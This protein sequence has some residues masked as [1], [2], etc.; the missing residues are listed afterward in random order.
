M[1]LGLT[2]ERIFLRFF[3]KDDGED[4]YEYL[5]LEE[6]VKYEPYSVM[7]KDECQQEAKRRS[8]NP[9]FYAIVLK[10]ENKVI[11]NIYFAQKQPYNFNTY[12]LGYILNPK[13]SNMG[14]ATEA[15][16]IIMRFGFL[17]ISIHRIIANCDQKN[18]RSI[19]L[20]ERVGMRRETASR[21]DVYF[22]YNEN[23]EPDWKDSY[24]YAILKEEYSLLP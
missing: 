7:S 2:S 11:G 10:S 19:K 13:Y 6:V 17:E 16:K 3:T 4:I 5:S 8:N 15:V 14:Y 18:E 21:K 12:E 23:G 1:I 24:M 22:K 9:N 20:L